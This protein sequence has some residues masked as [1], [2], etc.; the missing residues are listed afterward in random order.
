VSHSAPAKSQPHVV[1]L[2]TPA[3]A[4]VLRRLIVATG[5]GWALAF[6]VVGL[7][8]RLELYGDGAI[9]SYAVAIQSSW[10]V[11]WRNIAA[12]LFVHVASHLP[13]EAYV[14]LTGDAVGAVAVY[15]GLFFAAPLI[16]LL[17][18]YVADRSPGRRLFTAACLSTALQ[19]PLVFGCPTELWFAHALFWPT[20]ALCHYAPLTL[21][22][23]A[24]T[25]IA[26]TAMTLTHE[27][28][29][30]FAAVIVATTAVSG[31]PRSGVFVRAGA[32]L[33]VALTAFLAIKI[34]FPPDDYFAPVLARAS[35][36]VID[37]SH[38]ARPICLVIA[39]AIAAYAGAY[40]ALRRQASG[41][42]AI[43]AGLVAMA[44]LATYWA[45]ADQ[46]IHAVDRYAVR[47]VLLLGTPLVAVLVVVMVFAAEDRLL[48]WAALAKPLLG[49]IAVVPAPAAIGALLV[50]TLVHGVETA[51][52]VGAW[53]RYLSAVTVLATGIA[54]DP[55]L[56]DVAFVASTR[57]P[58]DLDRLG[59]NS[60]TP[61]LSVMAA[62]GLAPTRL[63]VD[64]S[65]N[66]IW[67][68][69]ASARADEAAT[70]AVPAASRRLLRIHACLHPR[71]WAS[72]AW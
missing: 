1:P 65:A 19:C 9:F 66:Y 71:R 25:V 64:P 20:L 48:G 42:R 34:A 12:R 62:P 53:T 46:S 70:R 26:V 55:E 22:G 38:F 13:A 69:C 63:I 54:S 24:M 17:L 4:D 32:A 44:L 8:A 45:F 35:R 60:T 59:W 57:I 72:P 43:C 23:L 28:A 33:A 47:T 21:A 41:L 10:D 30:I 67:I 3:A 14:G 61:Y 36:H 39:A 5:L 52:F 27:G 11:H 37:L 40:L 56:G 29:L 58:R 18:T 6:V 7:A 2:A 15:G 16:G 68:S 50:V 51:K 49:R 31:G